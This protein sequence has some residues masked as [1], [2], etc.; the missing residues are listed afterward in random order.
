VVHRALEG[1]GRSRGDRGLGRRAE[2]LAGYALVDSAGWQALL[3][4]KLACFGLSAG[5]FGYVSWVLWPRRAFATAAELPA[6][7]LRF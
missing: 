2:L 4:A 3:A 6:L 5:G 7:K 1:R